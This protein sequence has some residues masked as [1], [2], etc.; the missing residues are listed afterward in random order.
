LIIPKNNNTFEHPEYH[1]KLGFVH[2][3]KATHHFSDNKSVK[4]YCLLFRPVW[5]T[6]TFYRRVLPPPS[7]SCS[8][9]NSIT[10]H[11]TW[12]FIKNAARISKLTKTEKQFKNKSSHGYIKETLW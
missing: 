10:S 7:G 9:Q 5:Y 6:L 4:N 8:P 2:N 1:I 11:N 12:I 3:Y